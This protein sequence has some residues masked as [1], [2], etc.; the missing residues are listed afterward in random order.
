MN[1]SITREAI[2]DWSGLK[3]THYHILYAIWLL[4]RGNVGQIAFYQGNDLLARPVAP[5]SRDDVEEPISLNARADEHDSWIQIKST[6]TQWSPQ[7]FLPADTEKEN[8]LKNLICNAFESEKNGRHW[9]VHL[10]TQGTIKRN[11][12]EEF[13]ANPSRKRKLNKSL[14]EI[15]KRSQQDLLRAGNKRNT[16]SQRKLRALGWIY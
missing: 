12:L 3:G 5:P 9:S 2:G 11:D 13:V 8:L 16:I 15:V 6:D 10:I 14:T 4:L 1:S 7:R